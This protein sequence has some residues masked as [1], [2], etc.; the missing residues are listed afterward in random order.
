M[1]A[2]EWSDERG[3]QRVSK[4]RGTHPSSHCGVRHRPRQWVPPALHPGGQCAA[5]AGAA[6]RPNMLPR[7]TQR[8]AL[9]LRSAAAARAPASSTGLRGGKRLGSRAVMWLEL[10]KQ[11]E[12][13]WAHAVGPTGPSCQGPCGGTTGRSCQAPPCCTC[14]HVRLRPCS[15][16]LLRTGWAP[17]SALPPRAPLGCPASAAAPPQA[18]TLRAHVPLCTSC[19]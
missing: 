7:S 8:K 3:I 11:Q 2:G 19:R 16:S 14:S 10:S 6:S 12:P 1:H 9:A 4:V 15:S 17:A 18:L 5:G 13:C